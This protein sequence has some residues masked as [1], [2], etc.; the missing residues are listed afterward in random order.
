MLADFKD[1]LNAISNTKKENRIILTGLTNTI[2]MPT[3]V[4][5]RKV[6]LNNM[7]TS[8]LNTICHVPQQVT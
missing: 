3:G 5:E 8:T 2:P 7:I 1:E 6:W 4:E